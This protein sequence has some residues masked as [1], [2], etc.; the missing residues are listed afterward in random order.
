M[1]RYS[2]GYE[3]CVFWYGQKTVYKYVGGGEW[4]C[5]S[6]NDSPARYEQLLDMVG[7]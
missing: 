2:I 1:A 4:E 5:V 7:K 6:G 3:T